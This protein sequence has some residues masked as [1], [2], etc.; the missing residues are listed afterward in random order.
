V[1]PEVVKVIEFK[2]T[3]KEKIF[4]M[5]QNCPVC[6]SNTI[7]LEGEAVKRCINTNCPAQV[8]ERIKHFASKG[9][10]DID[11][12]GDKLV[13]QMVDKGMLSSYA[14]IFRLD[15]KN[16][17]GLERMGGKS[18]QNLID[19]I[20][21]SK[22][23]SFGRFLYALGIRYVGK[24]VAR[25]IADEFNSLESLSGA[26]CSNLKAIDGIGPV[27]AKSVE[28]FLNEFENI[29][30]I[31]RILDS[32]VQIFYETYNKE[33]RLYGKLFVLTGTLDGM[34]RNLAKE[35]LL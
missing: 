18:A 27:A 7:R 9:A 14:D 5:P 13:E 29:K 33:K 28:S 25:V 12:L 31:D 22:K 20:E 3:G 30:T 32:G 15:K 17:E 23:I 34:A 8:K 21:D 2:R 11:G 10:F 16:L 4:S 35:T 1:I 19:A 6:G 24:H 26:S